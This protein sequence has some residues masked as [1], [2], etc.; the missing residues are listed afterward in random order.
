MDSCATALIMWQLIAKPIISQAL[1]LVLF[2][3]SYPA[4][5]CNAVTCGNEAY[6]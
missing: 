5:P 6:N 2:T 4:E 3:P 1:L